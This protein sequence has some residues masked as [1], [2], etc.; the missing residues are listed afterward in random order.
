MPAYTR[1]PLCFTPRELRHLSW[2]LDHP[3]DDV[4]HMSNLCLRRDFLLEK[5]RRLNL[6]FSIVH[7]DAAHPND[8]ATRHTRLMKD[9]RDVDAALRSVTTALSNLRHVS[10]VHSS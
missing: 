10:Y 8:E 1:S 6:A 3:T 4:S 7:G 5:R 2:E 9:R